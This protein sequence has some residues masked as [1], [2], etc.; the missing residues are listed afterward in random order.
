MTIPE[1][2]K[3]IVEKLETA[4]FHPVTHKGFPLVKLPDSHSETVRLLK[5]CRTL[6]SDARIYAEGMLFVPVGAWEAAQHYL[7]H[8]DG[9]TL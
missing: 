2:T 5:F 3:A 7:D 6:E 8:P 1:W 9:V 4:G